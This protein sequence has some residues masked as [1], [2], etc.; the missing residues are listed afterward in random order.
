MGSRLKQYL[1]IA[2]AGAALY[3]LLSHHIIFHGQDANFVK[4]VYLLKKSTLHLHETFVSLNQKS[5]D[6]IMKVRV[7][8]EDG[9]GELLVDIGMIDDAERSRLESKYR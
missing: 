2:A 9:I 5:P 8:R 3:F 4:N 6:A 7:L 1:F